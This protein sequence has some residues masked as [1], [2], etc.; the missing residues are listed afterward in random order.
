MKISPMKTKVISTEC[1]QKQAKIMTN[2]DIIQKVFTFKYLG[3]SL[4]G[5]EMKI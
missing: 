3:C 4:S 2:G 1:E 5:Y